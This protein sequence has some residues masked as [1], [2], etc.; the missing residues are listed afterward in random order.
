AVGGQGQAAERAADRDGA[1]HGAGR[2]VDLADAARV[3]VTDPGP[4]AVGVGDDAIRVGG[5]RDGGDDLA[6]GR[7]GE[8]DAGRAEAGDGGEGPAA[9][10]GDALGLIADGDLAQGLAGGG[11]DD[12]DGAVI[13]VGREQPLAVGGEVEQAVGLTR[14]RGGDDANECDAEGQQ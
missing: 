7:G 14:P 10:P 11:V 8:D 2:D 13:G 1:G 4:A 6:R 12:G 3:V 5:P 9:E